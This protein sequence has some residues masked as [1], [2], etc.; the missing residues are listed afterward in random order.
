MRFWG[1]QTPFRPCGRN[2]GL[3]PS[4]RVR[5]ATVRTGVI[6]GQRE[7]VCQYLTQLVDRDVV[8]GGELLDGVAPQHLA[9]L[10]GRD[11]QVLTVADPGFDLIAKASPLQLGDDSVEPTLASG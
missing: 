1:F 11:R 10:I 4:S 5:E 9:Q 2:R 8:L 6:H 3:M 7:L